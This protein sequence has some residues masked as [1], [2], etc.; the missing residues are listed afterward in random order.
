M[1][2]IPLGVCDSRVE[3]HMKRILYVDG[4]HVHVKSLDFE[5]ARVVVFR[6]NDFP[7]NLEEG[8]EHFLL[9][10]NQDLSP[11]EIDTYIQEHTVS[12]D[13]LDTLWFVNPTEL[14]SIPDLWHAH[15]MVRRDILSNLREIV[16]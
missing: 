9:W 14:K 2:R 16:Q 4:K 8:V 11:D 13:P 12:L 1:V 10:S 15:V 5:S 7:Y 3:Y 6:K